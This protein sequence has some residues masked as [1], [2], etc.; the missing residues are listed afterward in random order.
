MSSETEDVCESWRR[1][2]LEE[3][4]KRLLNLDLG[5]LKQAAKI[6]QMRCRYIQQLGEER[7][8]VYSS[9]S[10]RITLSGTKTELITR[11][12]EEA[13]E[14][15]ALEPL[16]Y[17]SHESTVHA[18]KDADLLSSS[19]CDVCSDDNS[20]SDEDNSEIIPHKEP[21]VKRHMCVD[22][23][24]AGEAASGI[25]QVGEAKS[26][27]NFTCTECPAD[28][29]LSD[30]DFDSSSE[31]DSSL[32]LNQKTELAVDHCAKV[33]IVAPQLRG[34]RAM[35]VDAVRLLCFGYDAFRAG[36]R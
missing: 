10:Q 17:E 31:D 11:L 25:S 4:H 23:G 30:S 2:A 14:F 29:C 7:G 12:T 28:V 22:T 20:W 1:F 24:P 6:A 13:Y 9:Y 8:E 19:D 35:S 3:H 16:L 26:S 5:Q 18:R 34:A 15:L 36:Q 32:H 21:K 33:D 27:C